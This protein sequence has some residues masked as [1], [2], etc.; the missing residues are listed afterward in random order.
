MSSHK[1]LALCEKYLT[2][3][4]KTIFIFHQSKKRGLVEVY[5]Q[6]EDK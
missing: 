2:L 6:L 4:W 1:K 3:S 5:N